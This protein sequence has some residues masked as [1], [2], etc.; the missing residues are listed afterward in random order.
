MAKK[1]QLR[2]GT[3]AEHNSFTGALGEVTVD[4]T[5]NTIVVHDGTTV[6]GHP[7]ALARAFSSIYIVSATEPNITSYPELADGA[8]WF[9]TTASILKFYSNGSWTSVTSTGGGI[10]TPETLIDKTIQLWFNTVQGTV[11]DFNNCITDSANDFVFTIEE[12]T[13]TNK[14]L[15]NPIFT[16]DNFTLDFGSSLS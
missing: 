2:R 7:V 10:S 15:N 6:G 16:G 3:T 4:T 12:Q 5:K 11:S 9:D 8:L 1:I 14:T 13:L